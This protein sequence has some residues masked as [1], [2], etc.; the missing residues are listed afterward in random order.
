MK[1]G[2]KDMRLKSCPKGIFQRLLTII[3]TSW[4]IV[5]QQSCE[6]VSIQKKWYRYS[7]LPSLKL[8]NTLCIWKHLSCHLIGQDSRRLCSQWRKHCNLLFFFFFFFFTFF[9][10]GLTNMMQ[11]DMFFVTSLSGFSF[12]LYQSFLSLRKAKIAGCS[13]ILITRKRVASVQNVKLF[14]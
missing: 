1:A 5:W 2:Y 10:P 11:I 14:L 6:P 3:W 8:M 9:V 13:Y 4:P 12:Y 7:E